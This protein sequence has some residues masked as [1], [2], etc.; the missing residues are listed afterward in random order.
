MLLNEDIKKEDDVI[1]AESLEGTQLIME[2]LVLE[3]MEEDAANLQ[4]EDHDKRM[5]KIYGGSENQE[6]LPLTEADVME[7]M[8]EGLLGTRTKS[9]IK[10]GKNDRKKF[11]IQKSIIVI[12]R[13]NKDPLYGKLVKVYKARKKILGAL[14]RKY[15]TKAVTRTRK[16]LQNS[17][18]TNAGKKLVNKIDVNSLKPKSAFKSKDLPR[19]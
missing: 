16:I 8:N 11:L 12:A 4:P 7:L 5:K 3:A 17:T 18:S 13:E 2:A 14:R 9:L 15:Q 10:W 19:R 6:A 1:V